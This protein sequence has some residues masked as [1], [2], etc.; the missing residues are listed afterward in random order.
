MK[1]LLLLL[2]I[3]LFSFGQEIEYH[4][5]TNPSFL[6]GMYK[7]ELFDAFQWNDK[8]GNNI[9]ILCVETRPTGEVEGDI[10][11]QRE[12]IYAFHYIIKNLGKRDIVLDL[13]KLWDIKDWVE[14]GSM[15][16]SISFVEESIKITDLDNDNIAEVTLGYTI[17]G[18]SDCCWPDP[19]KLIMHEEGRKYA[20]RGST[21]LIDSSGAIKTGGE[22]NMYG[23]DSFK[24]A[25]NVF[26][27][28]ASDLYDSALMSYD[29]WFD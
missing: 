21:A 23:K 27:N 13:V 15:D 25:P 16:G 4:K 6:N 17:G 29:K 20:I 14:F 18:G 19:I 28:F 7:G 3:P 1:K 22:K 10:E 9:F 12:T 11:V 24:E 2:I 26:T 5:I 8:L